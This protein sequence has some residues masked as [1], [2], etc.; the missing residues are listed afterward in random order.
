M[1][2]HVLMYGQ[3]LCRMPGLPN[4]WSD[5]HRWTRDW[6]KDNVTCGTC[7]T[8]LERIEQEHEKKKTEKADD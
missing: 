4:T 2:V 7:K 6:D 5:E 1:I 8:E 3:T